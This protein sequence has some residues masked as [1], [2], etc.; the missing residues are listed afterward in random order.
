MD[1]TICANETSRGRGFS[2]SRGTAGASA[3]IMACGAA[4]VA[5]LGVGGGS[6]PAGP[7]V[8][9]V[10]VERHRG[11][12]L[13]RGPRPKRTAGRGA[14][15]TPDPVGHCGWGVRGG[16]APRQA[17]L[18]GH[19]SVATGSMLALPSLS[20]PSGPEPACGRRP[21]QHAGH[22]PGQRPQGG[23]G[24]APRPLGRQPQ[25]RRGRPTTR[26]SS[27]TVALPAAHRFPYPYPSETQ[28]RRSWAILRPVDSP[29]GMWNGLE[30]GL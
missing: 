29:K 27:D 10:S 3:L 8:L 21:S 28:D 26:H 9:R 14:A 6:P 25:V 19:A 20:R 7:Q 30:T 16:A 2:A 11:R 23:C 12:G 22:R 5:A 15:R 4:A 24:Q 17:S 13:A 18:R 1:C